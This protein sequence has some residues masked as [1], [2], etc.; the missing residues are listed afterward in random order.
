[1]DRLYCRVRR[2]EVAATPEEQVRQRLIAWMVEKGCPLT[3]MVV[4][5][6]LSSVAL[7]P[8]PPRLRIDLLIFSPLGAPWLLVECKTAKLTHRAQL[9]LLSYNY[10]VGASWLAL[11]NSQELW[12]WAPGQQVV[13]HQLPVWKET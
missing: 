9:Q 10:W 3:F 2:C 12:V 7:A 6:A 5:R 11:A 13:H 4:E 1:M 8:H